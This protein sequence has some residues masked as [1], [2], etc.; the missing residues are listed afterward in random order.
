MIV[1]AIQNDAAARIGTPLIVA[2][3]DP[4]RYMQLGIGEFLPRIVGLKIGQMGRKRNANRCETRILNRDLE[5]GLILRPVAR[6][7]E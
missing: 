6:A 1:I 5:N 7:V 2:R 4:Q 3:S